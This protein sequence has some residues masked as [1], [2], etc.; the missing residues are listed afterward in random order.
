MNDE[1]NI[2]NIAEKVPIDD[3]MKMCDQLIEGLEQ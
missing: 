2:V 3:M 1:D